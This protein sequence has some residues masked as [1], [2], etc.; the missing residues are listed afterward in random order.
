MTVTH[1]MFQ[2]LTQYQIHSYHSYVALQEDANTGLIGP[3]IIY[4]QGKMKSTMASFREFP[5]LYNTFDENISWLSAE[6][7]ARLGSNESNQYSTSQYSTAGLPKGNQTVWKPQ[8]TNFL[9]SRQ[10]EA[11]P[12]FFSINGYVYANT[13]TFE[14]CLNDNVS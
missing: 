4:A 8:L 14:M 10:F 3:T 12:V 13:P 7:K 1:K 2:K 9:D 11:A 6:N 5:I